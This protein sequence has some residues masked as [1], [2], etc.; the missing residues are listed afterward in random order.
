MAKILLA[1]HQFF[2]RFY[3]GTEVLTLETAEEL[4]K[5]G[6][7]VKILAV[8]PILPGDT[9]PETVQIREEIYKG[10]H[11]WKLLLPDKENQ[12]QRLDFESE[13]PSLVA[14]FDCILDEYQPDVVHVFHLMRLT[15]TF[16]NRVKK[17]DVKIFFT[18][19]DFWMLCP[20]YQLIRH[21]DQLCLGPKA[22]RCM[23][24]MVSAYAKGLNP[25]PSKFKIAIKFP[26]VASIVNSSSR[27]CYKILK[28]R[29]IRNS[30]CFESFDGVIWSN[31]FIQKMFHL[32][33]LCNSN[34][35]I[36]PFPIPEDS[37]RMV[38]LPIIKSKNTLKVSFI[39]TMR[40]SK[41]PHILLQA[42]KLVN[43]SNIYFDF[44]GT[45]DDHQYIDNLKAQ[46]AEIKNVQFRGVFSQSEFP[47]V[48]KD[49]DAVVIPS[50]W[51]EN[52]PLTALSVLA[53][54]RILIVSDLGGLSSL[55]EHGVSG[56][57]FPAGDYKTLA[58]ILNTLDYSKGGLDKITRN[59]KPPLLIEPY[60]DQIIEKVW[61]TD[62]IMEVER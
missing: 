34:E 53:A 18:A 11:V 55:V 28:Q 49:T 37:R 50:I 45:S 52:T 41:G 42:A 60:I 5:R 43:N 19:T 20:T 47:E 44:W 32:N 33:G 24:C 29:K 26:K 54:K 12:I 27:K 31:P 4:R 22:D 17:R 2:P 58:N 48:L 14:S 21:N 40:S 7:E 39:G 30:S 61:K 51:Y 16:V 10:F 1:C 56:Y 38:D 35:Y 9:V 59:I 23:S 57:C 25:T 13:D 46:A 62:A 6:H 36:L 15:R 8:E 3:T